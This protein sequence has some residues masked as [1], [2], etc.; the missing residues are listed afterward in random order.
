MQYSECAD[1]Q[2]GFDMGSVRRPV[3]PSVLSRSSHCRDTA[4]HLLDEAHDSFT[5]AGVRSRVELAR[6]VSMGAAT[7]D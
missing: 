4:V 3:P 1:C 6:L 7:P 2:P 5:K